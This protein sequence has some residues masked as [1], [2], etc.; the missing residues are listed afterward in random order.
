MKTQDPTTPRTGGDSRSGGDG[1]ERIKQT[2]KEAASAAKRQ[3][4]ARLEEGKHSAATTASHAS[5][6]LDEV[7]STLAAEGH[8]TLAQAVHATSARISSFARYV[9]THNLD[10]LTQE[11]RRLARENP[12]LLI[13]GGVALGVALGRFF[14]AS[15]ASSAAQEGMGETTRTGGSADY[16]GAGADPYAGADSYAGADPHAE[17][18]PSDPN[19]LTTQ[20]SEGWRQP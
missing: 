5:E 17:Q 1:T 4:R 13:A 19:R 16:M 8:E 9:E 2:G 18:R 7:S 11:A 14:K 10:E 6:T 12:G 15:A 3:A 20:Q